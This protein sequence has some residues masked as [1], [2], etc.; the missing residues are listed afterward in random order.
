MTIL[1]P[2]YIMCGM[3]SLDVHGFRFECVPVGLIYEYEVLGST[4]QV[5]TIL[6]G[7]WY[8]GADCGWL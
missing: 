8:G 2:C 5:Y 4:A 3:C 1:P 7:K 6:T